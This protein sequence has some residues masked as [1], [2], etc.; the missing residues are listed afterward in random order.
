MILKALQSRN[1]WQTLFTRCEPAPTEAPADYTGCILDR[2]VKRKRV[3]V[4]G[5]PI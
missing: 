2:N 5:L 1:P 4:L 3:P